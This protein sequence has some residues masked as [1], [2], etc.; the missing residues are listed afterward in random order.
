M[1]SLDGAMTVMYL[2]VRQKFHW[3]V[4]DVT[5]FDTVSQLIPMLG[6]LIG[7]LILRKVIINKTQK[8]FQ[9]TII[10]M[11]TFVGFWPICDCIGAVVTFLGCTEQSC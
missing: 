3:S 2:F 9:D 4:R 10:N 11:L 6:A 8:L 7:F 1:I 5:F